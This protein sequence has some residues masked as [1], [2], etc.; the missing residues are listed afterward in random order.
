MS[1]ELHS[2]WWYKKLTGKQTLAL[3]IIVYKFGDKL[4]CRHGHSVASCSRQLLSPNP[5][6]STHFLFCSKLSPTGPPACSAS[7]SE[8]WRLYSRSRLGQLTSTR[9]G[10]SRQAVKLTQSRNSESESLSDVTGKSHRSLGV[11]VTITV[12]LVKLPGSAAN[13]THDSLADPAGP[14]GCPTRR[15]RRQV[16]HTGSWQWRSHCGP[17]CEPDGWACVAAVALTV[18]VRCLHC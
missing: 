5:A 9:P 18:P 1:F 4:M 13:V 15:A 17:H 14:S 7:A 16:Q 2:L 10:P 6:S 3:C 12:L 11:T 8:S